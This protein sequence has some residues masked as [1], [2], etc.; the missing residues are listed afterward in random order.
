MD[1]H[2]HLLLAK[3]LEQQHD[4][5]LEQWRKEKLDKEGNAKRNQIGRYR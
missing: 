3:L 1:V 2:R 4:Q 5:L